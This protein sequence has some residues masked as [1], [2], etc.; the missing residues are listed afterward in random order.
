MSHMAFLNKNKTKRLRK[1]KKYSVRRRRRKRLLWRFLLCF[2]IFFPSGATFSMPSI[3]TPFHTQ[4][5][6]DRKM[7]PG[8][9][10]P[11]HFWQYKG[12]L[13]LASRCASGAGGYQCCWC[14]NCLE[15]NAFA[16]FCIG[17]SFGFFNF[18]PPPQGKQTWILLLVC[19]CGLDM[20]DLYIYLPLFH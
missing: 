9:I 12:A 4:P 16:F 3:S 19:V 15:G 6:T 18:V 8:S 2:F 1:R 20:H 13:L 5:Q 11:A 10:N 17:L 14:K 7:H